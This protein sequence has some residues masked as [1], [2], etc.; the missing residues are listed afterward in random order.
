M[1]LD[2]LVLRSKAFRELMYYDNHN[3]FNQE[4]LITNCL[5]YLRS[6]GKPRSARRVRK[7]LQDNW[8]KTPIGKWLRCTYKKCGFEW[9]YFG[10]RNWAECPA[11]H[12][13]MKVAIA[14]RNYR[15]ADKE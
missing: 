13:T 9:Q 15:L 11:C 5:P 6:N 2:I 7:P 8:H 4:N 14:K 1:H 3:I 10:G 12:T